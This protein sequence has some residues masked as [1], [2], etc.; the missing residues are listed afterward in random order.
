MLFILNLLCCLQIALFYVAVLAGLLHRFPVSFSQVRTFIFS[1]YIE[2]H[3]FWQRFLGEIWH[4]GGRRLGR[5]VTARHVVLEVLR[6]LS[7]GKLSLLLMLQV[8]MRRRRSWKKSW[9]ARNSSNI[10]V[11]V[12]RLSN[13]VVKFSYSF[14]KWSLYAHAYC[15]GI[16]EES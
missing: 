2:I 16:L 8:L 10:S 6:C 14:W 3:A 13:F 11:I 12:R 9:Y 4:L 15:P 7:K 1:V 5:W